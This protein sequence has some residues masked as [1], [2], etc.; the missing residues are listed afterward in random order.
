MWA[1]RTIA[2]LGL[3]L[4]SPVA[5][6]DPAFLLDGIDTGPDAAAWRRLGPAA[7]DRIAAIAADLDAPLGRRARAVSVL[8]N[9]PSRRTRKFLAGLLA[10][11]AAPSLL[12]RKA[13]LALARAFGDASVAVLA[14]QAGAADPRLRDDVARALASIGSARARAVLQRRL[15]VET[16]WVRRTIERTLQ[17]AP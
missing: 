17:G 15:A 12:R 13:A 9:F 14:S 6:A 11:D 7:R 10:D 8:A 1:V 2:C 3:T 16:T 5:W 4:A